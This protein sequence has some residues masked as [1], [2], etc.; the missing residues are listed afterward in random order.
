MNARLFAAV[1]A[2]SLALSLVLMSGA[3]TQDKD[4]A[5]VLKCRGSV[6][7]QPHAGKP[8]KVSALRS[9]AGQGSFVVQP[10]SEV[11]FYDFRT[12]SRVTVRVP[13]DSKEVKLAVGSGPI[14]T[15]QPAVTV[16]ASQQLAA[17]SSTSSQFRESMG[18]ASSKTPTGLHN[19]SPTGGGGPP[20][21]PGDGKSV[22]ATHVPPRPG[23]KPPRAAQP[24]ELCLFTTE[25]NPTIQ[26]TEDEYNH[27]GPGD[28]YRRVHSSGAREPWILCQN[29]DCGTPNARKL[30]LSQKIQPGQ[31]VEYV[32]SHQAPTP[33]TGRKML[34]ARYPQGTIDSLRQQK[35]S[36]TTLDTRLEYLAGL[37]SLQLFAEADLELQGLIKDFPDSYDWEQVRLDVF[38][39]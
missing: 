28:F 36:A 38:Q 19:P 24:A 11:T 21:N 35:K 32:R 16:Q 3:Q 37:A 27:L 18:A 31:A 5:V 10:G 6:L 22:R 2:C 14:S 1:A 33:F 8:G 7:F 15:S 34:V 4:S 26:I 30:V 29:L 20:A 23:A 12:S 9:F 25:E 39:H 13:A 17:L